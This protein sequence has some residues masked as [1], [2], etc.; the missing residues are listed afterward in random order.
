MNC[1]LGQLASNVVGAQWGVTSLANYRSPISIRRK[2]RP[3]Q[4]KI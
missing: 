1:E 2:R 3:K 4:I